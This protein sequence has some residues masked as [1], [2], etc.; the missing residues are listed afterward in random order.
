RKMATCTGLSILLTDVARAVC[1]PARIVGIAEWTTKQG[2]HNWN[3]VWLPEHRA[4]VATEYDRDQHGLDRGWY[5]ADAARAIP[6][7]LW[8]GIYATSWARTAHHFPMV[9]NFQDTS[10]PAIEVTQR[11]VEI[12]RRHIP[13]PGQCEL[14]IDWQPCPCGPP[15]PSAPRRHRHQ[16][17]RQPVA[18]QR[19]EPIFYHQSRPRHALP[20]CLE[21]YSRFEKTD[22][23]RNHGENH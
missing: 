19:S 21:R 11:Y 17:R 5:L 14:R 15:C 6:G 12:G 7:S 18:D 20:N 22:F 1:L 13:A 10:I 23:S 16:P 4:W 9:W 8:H 2:N 3:E